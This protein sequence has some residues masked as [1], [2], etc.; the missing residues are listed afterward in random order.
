M[1]FI[2][3]V[4]GLSGIEDIRPRP[5]AQ[6]RPEWWKSVPYM[7][8]EEDRVRI[9]SGN[10][11]Q[12]PAFPE[13]LSNGFILPMWADT[14]LY[15][16]EAANTWNY[17]CGGKNSAF[18]INIFTQNQFVDHVDYSYQGSKPAKII[19]Q[20]V[21]PWYLLLPPGYGVFQMP[22]FY[23]SSGDYAVLPGTYEPHVAATDKLEVAV[24]SGNKEIFIKKG[25]PLVQYIPYKKTSIGMGVRDED[26]RDKKREAMKITR[27]LTTFRTWYG[28]N[29]NKNTEL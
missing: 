8:T 6:L 12:C 28:Q 29:T 5:A 25:T 19:F 2:S 3:R 23:H 18:K 17:R 14:T 21:N 13:F 4:P 1:E 27:S 26:E 10:V 22:L 20:F 9:F 16:D 15:Y 7:Q 24:F 11:R